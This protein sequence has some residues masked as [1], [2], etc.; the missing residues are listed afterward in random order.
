MN[1][2]DPTSNKHRYFVLDTNVLLHAP[3]CLLGF[4]SSTVVIPVD[5]IEELD[6]FKSR[7]DELGHNA[8]SAIRNI[9]L[10]TLV[11]EGF[12]LRPARQLDS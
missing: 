10:T 3:S 5:V 7:N 11:N 1:V 6:K 2:N 8:R 9:K 12:G 4:G